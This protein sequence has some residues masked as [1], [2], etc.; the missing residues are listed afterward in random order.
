[1]RLMFGSLTSVIA[2]LMIGCNAV[3]PG[4]CWPNTSGGLGG[5]GPLPIGAGVGATTTGDY[6]ADAPPAEPLDYGGTPNPCMAGGN[7]SYFHPSD[8][9][10]VVTL[11]DDGTDVGGGYQEAKAGLIF[12]INTDGV[13]ACAIWIGM[14]LRSYA[15]GRVPPNIAAIYVAKVANAI[16]KEMYDD[17]DTNLPAGV[18]CTKFK[19]K[20]TTRLAKQYAGMGTSVR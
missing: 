4:D 18:F 10:F 12:A 6:Y 20:M 5:G 15:W 3:D 17:G 11:A 9:P 2:M 7:I 1:M 19:K 13:A 16:T 14:P 8:F